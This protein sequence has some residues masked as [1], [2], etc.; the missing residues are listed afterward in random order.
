MSC[1]FRG[2]DEVSEA[3]LWALYTSEH[4]KGSP[5][6]V[7]SRRG[8]LGDGPAA[9]YSV[10]SQ[11]HLKR[12]VST[13][14]SSTSK[15]SGSSDSACFSASL[16]EDRNLSLFEA[17]ELEKAV[18]PRGDNLSRQP[19]LNIVACLLIW[20]MDKTN[21]VCLRDCSQKRRKGDELWHTSR[22]A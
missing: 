18:P 10:V 12:A 7:C 9:P 15:E 19:P 4:T 8:M 17:T 22:C 11:P 6:A 14:V 2:A 5:R 16:G 21:H 3:D 13:A 1:L 20:R